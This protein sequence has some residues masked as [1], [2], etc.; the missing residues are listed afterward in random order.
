MAMPNNDLTLYPIKFDNAGYMSEIM[1]CVDI[2][3][4]QLSDRMHDVLCRVI[5]QCSLAANVM[6]IEAQ[7][8]VKEI[9]RSITNDICSLEVGID[10]GSIGDEQTYVRVMVS[11]YGN[12]EVWARPGGVAWTKHVNTKRQ[13]NVKTEYR[14]PFFEQSDNSDAMMKAFEHDMQKHE[15][16][17]MD[18]LVAMIQAIDVSKYLI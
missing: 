6:I 11:L 15:R 3:F 16:D 1:K 8:Q 13:N 14:L 9:S 5:S 10:E 12:H 17:F 4:N 7:R 18:N 2:A